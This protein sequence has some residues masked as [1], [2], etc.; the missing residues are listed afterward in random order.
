MRRPQATPAGDMSRDWRLWIFN[1]WTIRLIG[2]LKHILRSDAAHYRSAAMAKSISDLLLSVL[3][4]VKPFP[5]SSRGDM[6]MY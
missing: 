2:S 4:V 6:A 3:A 1:I 5:V